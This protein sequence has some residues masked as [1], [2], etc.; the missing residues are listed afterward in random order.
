MKTRKKAFEL[1]KAGTKRKDIIEQMNG[2]GYR[3][4][5][6]NPV[7]ASYLSQIV[8]STRLVTKKSVESNAATSSIVLIKAAM[9]SRLSDKTKLQVVK[10]LVG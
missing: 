3:T 5:Q 10:E 6:G 2:H 1:L 7:T 9:K 4:N 8:S